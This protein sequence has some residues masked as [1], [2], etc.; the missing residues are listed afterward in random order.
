MTKRVVSL[1]ALGYFIDVLDLFLFSVLRVPSLSGLGV[2]ASR[3]LSDGVL[4]LNSQMLGL[5]LGCFVW[6]ILGD[7][8]GRV[9]VLYGSL[10][11]YSLATLANGLV[12]S[13]GAYAACRLL[14]G[15]G[16]A[17]ELGA[18]ITLV[19]E[20]LPQKQRGLGTTLVATCG[21][22]GGIAAAALAQ[23][24]DWRTCY[25]I[26]GTAGLVLLS[27]R[28]KLY[29][30]K[31][32]AEVRAQSCPRGSLKQLLGQGAR[33]LLYLRLIVTGL[34]I[35]FVAGI[36]MV[37][38]PEFARSLHVIGPPVTAA[39][40][41]LASYIGAALGDLLCGL[42][43]QHLRSRKRAMALC[44]VLLG[45]GIVLYLHAHGVRTQT[46]YALCFG[47]GLCT[48]YWAVLITAAAESFGTNLRAT[49]ATTVPNLVR[50]GVIPMTLLFEH[51]HH[52]L[53]PLHAALLLGVVCLGGALWSLYHLPETY[54]RS[55]DFIESD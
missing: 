40:A 45:V 52:S 27:L 49:V 8:Y 16:L 14:A 48:G 24:C 30:P 38:S 17:G 26:G 13:V 34:P 28:I 1:A 55:L 22:C 19:S 6:G 44:L 21:L 32:F 54:A 7:R 43:S 33:R 18:A 4:L 5:L 50:A 51:L 37:F 9:R 47:V 53:G 11:L 36:L 39:Q 2:P 35:W 20:V 23:L 29:E 10:L 15:F 42:L 46:Y 41:V 3:H 25:F 12:G 31:L